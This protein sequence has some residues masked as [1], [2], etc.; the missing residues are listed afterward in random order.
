MTVLGPTF[1][2]FF[3][4]HLWRCAVH[5]PQPLGDSKKMESPARAFSEEY[6][7]LFDQ[8]SGQKNRI[9]D[10]AH[11]CCGS[12]HQINLLSQF[13]SWI[14]WT[15]VCWDGLNMPIHPNTVPTVSLFVSQSIFLSLS[16]CLSILLNITTIYR[17]VNPLFVCLILFVYLHSIYIN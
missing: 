8:S 9:F 2:Q 13:E 11:I 1:L 5:G 17:S 3:G 7:Q 15:S 14:V 16:L 10:W 4:N 12:I 6:L